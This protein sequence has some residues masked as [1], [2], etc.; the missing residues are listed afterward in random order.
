MVKSEASAGSGEAKRA[1]ASAITPW[2]ASEVHDSRFRRIAA[3]TPDIICPKKRTTADPALPQ[4][5]I[6]Q[7][8]SGLA[9][10]L[11]ADNR[12]ERARTQNRT[13]LLLVALRTNRVESIPFGS[14]PVR[15]QIVNANMAVKKAGRD[16][17]NR[18]KL[19][20]S[21]PGRTKTAA[22]AVG[23]RKRCHWNQ[24]RLHNRCDHHLRDPL[25]T[26]DRKRHVAM[27]DQEDVDLAAIIR[28]HRAR[29]IQHRD[30]ML[31]GKPGTR[32]HLRFIA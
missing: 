17:S 3:T 14:R 23:C 2:R 10:R 5:M 16:E 18:S 1:V 11:Y 9:L 24:F 28:I 13:P 32:P 8:V 30:A 27:V 31:G 6:R 26:P 7:G 29:R 4:R 15:V 20:D 22:T 21:A 25:A 19:N 12:N